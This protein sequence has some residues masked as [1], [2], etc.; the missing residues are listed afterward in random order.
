MQPATGRPVSAADLQK[1]VGQHLGD[2]AP[3]AAASWDLSACELEAGLFVPAA[4]VKEARRRA[5]AALLEARRKAAL[6]TAEGLEPERDVVGEL[7][8]QIRQAG[9]ST[10]EASLDAAADAGAGAGAGDAVA[11]EAAAGAGAE[12]AQETE[13]AS[14]SGGGGSGA[15]AARALAPGG[16][17][18]PLLR[19]A[20]ARASGEEVHRVQ[21]AHVRSRG[22]HE[23]LEAVQL[24]D[25]HPALIVA[26]GDRLIGEQAW[27]LQGVLRQLP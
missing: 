27:M 3:L 23:L 18:H 15:A 22:W 12:A 14:T 13:Q 7:L 17:P 9:A 5:V 26:L 2:E 19:C 1:A 10:D 16:D 24:D 21:Q 25:V 4:A 20:R 6:A 8:A 11:A